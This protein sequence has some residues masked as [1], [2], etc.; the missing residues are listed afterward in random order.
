MSSSTS[1]SASASASASTIFPASASA[2]HEEH[3]P[4]LASAS[5]PEQASS[6]EP[7]PYDESP[8]FPPQQPPAWNSKPSWKMILPPV[9][10]GLF[11]AG[12]LIIPVLNIYLMRACREVG[13]NP[14]KDMA[15]CRASAEANAMAVGWTNTITLATSFPSVVSLLLTGVL[16]DRIGR[17]PFIIL[18][19]IGSLLNVLTII[20]IALGAPIFVAYISAFILGGFGAPGI[21]V[22]TYSYLADT[23]D[24]SNRA[25]VFAVTDSIMI[26][27]LL[28]SPFISG[29]LSNFFGSYL[30]PTIVSV[31][32][33]VICIF[34]ILLFVP[35]SLRKP[36][37]ATSPVAAVP[38]SNSSY[39]TT[40]STLPENA[41]QQTLL[42][43]PKATQE[44]SI[45]QLVMDLWT[46]ILMLSRGPLLIFAMFQALSAFI[47]GGTMSY[48]LFYL[49]LKF[50]WGRLSKAPILRVFES[51]A[52][53]VGSKRS[54]KDRTVFELRLITFALVV[55]G[56]GYSMIA[57]LTAGWQLYVVLLFEGFAS[58]L[59]PLPKS[60]LS[61]SMPEKS[62]GRLMA[63]VSFIDNV[64]AT[65]GSLFLAFLYQRTVTV[66]PGVTFFL[67]GLVAIINITLI[68]L[69]N[70]DQLAALIESVQLANRTESGDAPDADVVENAEEVFSIKRSDSAATLHA[71]A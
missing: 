51:Y 7:P 32:L 33:L 58:I 66:M 67:C 20:S 5:F 47:A 56:V 24:V 36:N 13:I 37:L 16:M 3:T 31:T 15:A 19:A 64:A 11:G 35:E 70:R 26:L 69:V 23:S 27:S 49:S 41:D 39:G 17:K 42:D 55:Y 30:V 43:S 40:S 48:I 60:I 12:L 46:S 2:S 65:S 29:L 34:W 8:S 44:I 68:S 57:L 18:N 71:E 50:G 4:L 9:T 10:M 21:M 54:V 52:K 28:S 61:K 6:V 25:S 53:P 63:S 14:D 38:E 45:Y 1:A 62:Q 22:A 59:S